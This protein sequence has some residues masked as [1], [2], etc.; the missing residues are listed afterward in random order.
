MS[1]FLPTRLT[2]SPSQSSVFCWR[3]KIAL[4]L[5]GLEPRLLHLYGYTWSGACSA[6]SRWRP[7]ATLGLLRS[8][9]CERRRPDAVERGRR[10]R[11]RPSS[12]L[13]AR[14]SADSSARTRA[15]LCRSRSFAAARF[16][17]VRCFRSART[18]TYVWPSARHYAR[19]SRY[20][21]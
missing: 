18:T 11:N 13:A 5:K 8:F 6:V 1:L 21:D 7:S 3:P 4:T 16:S 10:P 14:S 15:I 9:C 19:P 20:I 17:S 2:R 12:S